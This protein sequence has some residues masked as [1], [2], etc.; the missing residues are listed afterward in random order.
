MADGVRLGNQCYA[1]SQQASD[2]YYSAVTPSI[3][4]GPTTYVAEYVKSSGAWLLRLTQVQTGGGQSSVTTAAPALALPPC[5]PLE[6]FKDGMTVGWGVVAAM[7]VA[8]A[9]SVVRRGL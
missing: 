8:W 1:S 2:A 9:V 3:T 6:N 5:D 4:P 7:A